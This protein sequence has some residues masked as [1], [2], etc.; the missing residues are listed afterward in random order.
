MRTLALLL[1]IAP[2]AA[3]DDGLSGGAIAGIIIGSL[4]GVGII[5]ALVWHF[6]LRKNASMGSK[7][8]MASTS[9]SI[10]ENALPM[11][12]LPVHGDDDV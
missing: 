2:L 1:A 11:V 4:A 8:N 6:Y 3:A 7:L 10:G 5:G 12:A 9:R